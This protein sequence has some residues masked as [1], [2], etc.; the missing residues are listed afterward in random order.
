MSRLCTPG[1]TRTPIPQVPGRGDTIAQKLFFI[2]A[3]AGVLMPIPVN[4][5][6]PNGQLQQ[7]PIMADTL[8]EFGLKE[9]AGVYTVARTYQRT[10]TV[11]FEAHL[12]RLEESA[13]LE[14]I[15]LNLDR[16]SLRNLACC[17]TLTTS[18]S[19]TQA[20]WSDGGYMRDRTPQPK[21]Q[22]K[23]LGEPPERGDQVYV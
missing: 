17:G 11:L 14:N 10:K 2:P 20:G 8:N 18:S 7:A 1:D 4:L 15:T 6:L 19:R 22:I 12:D 16:M 3:S 21:G 13:R 23:R 5:L 9:P